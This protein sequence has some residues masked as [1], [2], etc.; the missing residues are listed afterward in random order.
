MSSLDEILSVVKICELKTAKQ[1]HILTKAHSAP[2]GRITHKI[3]EAIKAG[4]FSTHIYDLNDA[5]ILYLQILGYYVKKYSNQP[6]DE[7]IFNVSWERIYGFT[8]N[9]CPPMFS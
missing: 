7:R 1:A 3:N 4:A 8:D 5:E 9:E 6:Q 2:F